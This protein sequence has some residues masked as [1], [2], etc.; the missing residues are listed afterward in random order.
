M[1]QCILYVPGRATE[2][3]GDAA[4]TGAEGAQMGVNRT[5]LELERAPEYLGFIELVFGDST[6]NAFPSENRVRNAYIHS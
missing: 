2:E 3:K 1:V 5:H 6:I 4:A